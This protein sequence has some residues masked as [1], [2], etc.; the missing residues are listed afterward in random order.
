MEEGYIKFGC[1]WEKT[2]PLSEEDTAE[3]NEFRQRLH[4]L[5]LIGQYPDGIGYG[6]IS[7]RLSQD[8]FLITGS[9]TGG[10]KQLTNNHF[11]L[12]IS[13]DFVR[14]E[15]HCSGPVQASSESLTHAA[16]YESQPQVSAVIHIHHLPTWKKW[17]NLLPTTDPKIEYGSPEMALAIQQ[18]IFES[19]ATSGI[20]IM[21]GH[22]EG[23]IAYGE[24]TQQAFDLILL[25]LEK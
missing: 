4:N 7:I 1:F 23:I 2:D 19:S 18:I 11:S 3:I 13:F 5:G 22:R 20:I 10:I 6:N 16:I 25:H 8:I 24:N 21:S 15:L 12:V 9:A 17:L 14:N